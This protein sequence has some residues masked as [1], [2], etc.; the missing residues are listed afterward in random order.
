MVLYHKSKVKNPIM[1]NLLSIAD[2]GNWLSLP[3][4]DLISMNDSLCFRYRV[5]NTTKLTNRLARLAQNTKDVC[6]IQFLC[7]NDK[8]GDSVDVTTKCI[9]NCQYCYCNTPYNK[10]KLQYWSIDD[11]YLTPTRQNA[12]RNYL[13]RRKDLVK[14]YP[15]RF[16]SLADFPNSHFGL[17]RKL[18]DICTETETKSIIVTKNKDIIPLV[19]NVATVTLYSIDTGK[20]NSPSNLETFCSL[21]EK[22]PNIRMFSMTVDFTELR[23]FY[24]MIE[25]YN[26]PMDSIQ[27]VAFHGQVTNTEKNK[28]P[29]N[30]QL[31]CL[32]K[33]EMLQL[34]TG[35][36][37]CVNGRC[38]SCSLL[39][40]INKKSITNYTFKPYKYLKPKRRVI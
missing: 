19:Y 39:C 32:L 27:F 11:L 36:A 15:L 23:W 37:C 28:A 29:V 4:S 22:Y 31:N 21:L 17:V 35:R 13:L 2:N 1:N 8:T 34:L 33:P 38:L 3:D 9:Y 16:G 6:N 26:I 5:E 18:L 20:Y 14:G 40:G 24:E 7:A 30:S 10:A 25:R 12:F